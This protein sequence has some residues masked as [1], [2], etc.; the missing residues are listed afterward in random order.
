MRAT[1]I[2][3]SSVTT[4]TVAAQ[5]ADAT[6]DEFKEVIRK[7]SCELAGFEDRG[8]FTAQMESTTPIPL[9]AEISRKIKYGQK[10]YG[11]FLYSGVVGRL[12]NRINYSL[13]D[14]NS[15]KI[16]LELGQLRSNFAE[17]ISQLEYSLEQQRS[18]AL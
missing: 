11:T 16:N 5:L 17:Q 3:N 4:S 7:A 15:L 10:K 6:L 9:F 2:Q 8:G 1:V 13:S 12:I 18:A 14:D